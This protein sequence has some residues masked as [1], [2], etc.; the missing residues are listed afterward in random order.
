MKTILLITTGGTIACRKNEAGV[1]SP[2]LR[3]RELTACVPEIA[4]ICEPRY[5]DIYQTPLDSTNIQLSD[6]ALMSEAIYAGLTQDCD[7]IVVTMGTDTMSYTA[8]M[9]SFMLIN[10]HKP[11]ILTGSQIPMTAPGTDGKQ[12]LLDAFQTALAG[13]PGI[14]IVFDGKIIYGTRASKVDALS[15]CAIEPINVPRAGSVTAGGVLMEHPIKIPAG[16]ETRMD[17]RVC[18]DVFLLKL[19]PGLVPD[20]IDTLLDLGFKG[21]VLEV[22]GLQ[23]IPTAS[24]GRASVYQSIKKVLERGK[25][26][27]I[28]ATTQCV[29]GE[30]N[31]GVYALGGRELLEAGL[32]PCYDMTTE[33]AVTKLMWLLG[34][35]YSVGEIKAEMLRN[36][37]GEISDTAASRAWTPELGASGEDRRD[38]GVNLPV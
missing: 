30:T 11:V 32:I 19:I 6:W 1:Y 17:N 3:G 8:A 38:S 12:N 10:P 2:E 9:L 4:S 34:H 25:T 37:C 29:K 15:S 22:F 27:P 31:F 23:G 26:I 33:A 35:D 7:G 24:D 21:I 14:Y 13:Y 20:K 28:A 16:G 5:N 36:Y 18:G